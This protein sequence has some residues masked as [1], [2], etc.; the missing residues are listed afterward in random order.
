MNNLAEIKERF[1]RDSLPVRLGG[2][3]ANLARVKSFSKNSQNQEAVFN[4]FE[5]SKHFIEW[6]AV[7]TETETTV[8][9]IEIQ[10]Q[11]AVWQR[12]WQKI[13]N[14]EEFRNK[15]AQTSA[16]WSKMV[17]EKSGLI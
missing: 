16:N 8:E 14:N 1:L 3:A 5:E 17:L 6:T 4:L 2:L 13:W 15:V 10:L 7:E 11:I 9:L 12:Q